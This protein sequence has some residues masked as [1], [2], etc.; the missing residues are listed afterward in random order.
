MKRNKKAVARDYLRIVEWSPEDRCFVGSAPPDR[1][2]LPRSDR[3]ERFL[4]RVPP[5]ETGCGVV[6]V[7]D[8]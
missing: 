8:R 4:L 1:P 5:P 3:G 2:L 6:S 7:T